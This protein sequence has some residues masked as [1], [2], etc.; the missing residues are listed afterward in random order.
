[1]SI[2]YIAKVLQ[3][4]TYFADRLMY[5][6]VQADKEL[7]QNGRPV[8]LRPG[9]PGFRRHAAIP[10]AASLDYVK[11]PESMTVLPVGRN[12]GRE[13]PSELVQGQG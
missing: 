12:A 1:M 10:E 11:R 6:D 13:K 3:A 8:K 2:G 5:L 7:D 9:D 4:G